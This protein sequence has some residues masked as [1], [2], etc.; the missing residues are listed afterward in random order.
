MLRFVIRRLVVAIPILVIS[1]ALVF[2]VVHLTT[3]PVAGLRT[4]PRISPEDI[5]RYRHTLGLDKSGPE[6]YRIWLVNFVKGNW[7]T[8]LFTG[9]GVSAEI[10]EALANS[11]VLGIAGFTLSL[12]LG[13]VIG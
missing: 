5:A 12:L 2:T 10:R 9:R 1:S 3:N 4:N 13:V 6:Q 8:S 7:G 11:L